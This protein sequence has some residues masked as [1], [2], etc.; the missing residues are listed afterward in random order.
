M[1]PGESSTV[2]QC[3]ANSCRPRRRIS[4]YIGK[5]HAYADYPPS[6][7]LQLDSCSTFTSDY[8]QVTELCSKTRFADAKSLD[9]YVYKPLNPGLE[10]IR[11]LYIDTVLAGTKDS[12]T[13]FVGR[14]H[15]LVPGLPSHT[16][17]GST[18]GETQ[19]M[20]QQ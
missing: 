12:K 5:R 4:K 20:S 15:T 9:R 3:S 1:D 8:N 13:T 6:S 7:F 10:E 14:L 17:F 11:L 19:N 18:F 2:E 16:M